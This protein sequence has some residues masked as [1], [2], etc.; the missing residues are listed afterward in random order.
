MGGF[1]SPMFHVS[2]H[3]RR[4]LRME[5]RRGPARTGR[6]PQKHRRC[7]SRGNPRGHWAHCVVLITAILKGRYW[8]LRCSSWRHREAFVNSPPACALPRSAATGMVY[9]DFGVSH[10]HHLQIMFGD[11]IRNRNDHPGLVEASAEAYG[12]LASVVRT[13]QIVVPGAGVK[14]PLPCSDPTSPPG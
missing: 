3:G 6:R 8:T 14:R 2:G 13:G 1:P 5:G 9:V 11:Y 12:A 7:A 10:P 4:M